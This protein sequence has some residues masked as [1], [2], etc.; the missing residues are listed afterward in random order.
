VTQRSAMVWLVAAAAVT[1]LFG[2]GYVAA[3]Q[4]VRH[5]ADHPQIEMARDAIGKLQAGASPE[6]VLPK[7]TIDLA[8]SKDPYLIVIDPGGKVLATSATLAGQRVIPPAGVFEYVRTHGEDVISWQPAPE[9]R[10]A[11]VVDGWEQG[12][13]VAGRSL[14]DTENLE[15]SLLDWTLGG[16]LVAMLV[17]GGVAAAR[18]RR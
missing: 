14:V 7:T 17:L 5:A 12:F 16:W 9:V 11:I 10:S 6:S 13:V 2:G 4:S 15:S 8:R 18:S 1:V 3:Q